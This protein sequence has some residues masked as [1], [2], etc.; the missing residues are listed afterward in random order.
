MPLAATCKDHDGNTPLHLCFWKGMSAD[1]NI[2][3]ILV[4]LDQ[5][6]ASIQNNQ[7]RVPLHY[8]C[9]FGARMNVFTTVLTAYPQ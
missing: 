4:E 6:A 5:N 3:N 1:I 7:K 2:V 8:L 9:D